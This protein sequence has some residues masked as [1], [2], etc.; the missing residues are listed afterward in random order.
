MKQLLGT[1]FV[2]GH[3]PLAT[4]EHCA[5]DFQGMRVLAG[6]E[7][8]ASLA[9]ALAEPF[10]G[11]SITCVAAVGAAGLVLAQEVA[12]RL[13]ARLVAAM[14]AHG[15]MRLVDGSTLVNGDRVLVVTDR[16]ITG[17]TVQ[18][19]MTLL[20]GSVQGVGALMDCSGGRLDWRVA[21]HA[22]TAV[23]AQRWAPAACPLCA[24]GIPL[25]RPRRG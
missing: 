14:Q 3:F 6:Q 12:R 21:F 11:A 2:E 13:D 20:G 23:P 8:T 4:G 16:V 5:V 7:G 18:A 19:L 1:G 10:R 9:D 17:V 15:V 25:W 24:R 22:L